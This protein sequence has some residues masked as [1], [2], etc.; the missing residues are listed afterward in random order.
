HRARSAGVRR[1]VGLLARL[2]RARGY[3]R[4]CALAAAVV[5]VPMQPMV[6]AL[7]FTVGASA[8]GGAALARQAGTGDRAVLLHGHAQLSG[9]CIPAAAA[10]LQRRR[11]RLERAHLGA[12]LW[13]TAAGA[14]A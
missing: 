2:E 10:G 8:A 5:L 7:V 6:P 14:A 12:D 11:G 9:E 3:R 13:H 4:A 1:A